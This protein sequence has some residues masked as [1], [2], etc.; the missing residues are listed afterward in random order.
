MYKTQNPPAAAAAARAQTP[1]SCV[2]GALGKRVAA[3]TRGAGWVPSGQSNRTSSC[4]RTT[5]KPQ[6]H[7]S[8]SDTQDRPASTTRKHQQCSCHSLFRYCPSRKGGAATSNAPGGAA[9]GTPD[10]AS[11]MVLSNPA[12]RRVAGGAT[13][14]ARIQK[15]ASLPRAI[16]GSGQI[17]TATRRGSPRTTCCAQREASPPAT[18]AVHAARAS[19]VCE[20]RTSAQPTWT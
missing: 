8:S 15:T 16:A 12:Q 4:K 2:E 17:L 3:T 20:A 6:S 19:C 18:T 7:I 9:M 14:A 5:R 10:R 13:F 11:A 1:R